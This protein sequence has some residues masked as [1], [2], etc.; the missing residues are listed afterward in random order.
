MA[1]QPGTESETEALLAGEGGISSTSPPDTPDDRP[2]AYSSWYP[3]SSPY[4]PQ[5]SAEGQPPQ[6][7]PYSYPAQP[8]PTAGQASPTGATG[9]PASAPP[10][11]APP[12]SYFAKNQNIDV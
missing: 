12:V 7:T 1:E 2:T 10:S 6:P 5:P 3:A 4:P 9:Y 8:Y 11:S